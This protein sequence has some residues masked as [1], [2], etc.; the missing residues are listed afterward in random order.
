MFE[1]YQWLAE[2]M[3]RRGRPLEQPAFERYRD[4]SATT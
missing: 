4:W 3:E 1:W 2:Q